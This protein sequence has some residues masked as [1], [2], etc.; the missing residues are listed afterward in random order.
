MNM[1]SP[2]GF[3]AS[4]VLLLGVL[5]SA[6][7]ELAIGIGADAIVH[8]TLGASFLLIALAV[9]DFKL[10]VWVAWT[11][12]AATG[13][14]AIVFLLQGASDVMHSIPLTLLAYD[15]LGQRLERI[16]GYIFLLWCFVLLLLDSHGRTKLLGAVIIAAI[17]CLEVYSIG[18]AYFGGSAAGI[19]KLLYVPLFV[20][21]LLESCK[22]RRTA[23]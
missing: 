8:L 16:L 1:R 17:L 13:I 4:L 19:L 21:L 14:L 15:V 11:A 20:W 12:C 7:T 9:F 18:M 23:E 5:L 22:P 6:L 2:L 10:P 3:A